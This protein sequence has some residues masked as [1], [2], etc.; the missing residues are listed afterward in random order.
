MKWTIQYRKTLCSIYSCTGNTLSLY[1]EL[2]AYLSRRLWTF[3]KIS[4]L[5]SKYWSR[6]QTS[7]YFPLLT[8]D[9]YRIVYAEL[10]ETVWIMLLLFLSCRGNANVYF[11][12][13]TKTTSHYVRTLSLTSILFWDINVKVWH[14][15]ALS[16]RIWMIPVSIRSA[17]KVCIL[18]T[19]S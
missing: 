15:I 12:N 8:F 16:N 18:Q 4:F 14:R 1:G 7:V 2:Q 9:S 3:I 17:V 6:T 19:G 11:S 5:F 13:T 10:F